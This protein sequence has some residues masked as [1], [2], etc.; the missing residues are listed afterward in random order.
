MKNQLIEFVV[1]IIK[2]PTTYPFSV[3]TVDYVSVK[4]RF[5]VTEDATNVLEAYVRL[6]REKNLKI[7]N[8]QA[9]TQ[10]TIT[11]N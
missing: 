8:M 9:D 6:I 4:F 11:I 2:N 7:V 1:E 10:I 3:I 5:N